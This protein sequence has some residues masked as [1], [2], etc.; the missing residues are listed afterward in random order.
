[1]NHTH[2]RI[3]N[4]EDDIEITYNEQGDMER[5]ITRSTRVGD[6]GDSTASGS[7]LPYSE[8]RYSY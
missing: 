6:E 8:V 4:R 3:F 7:G 2:R 5:E 1:M